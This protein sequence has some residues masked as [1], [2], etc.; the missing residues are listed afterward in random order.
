MINSETKK[1]LYIEDNIADIRLFEEA[2]SH[3]NLAIDLN[4]V[5]D[6]QELIDYFTESKKGHY[7]DLPELIITDLNLP[8][9]SGQKVIEVLKSDP[10][11]KRIPVI[12]FTTSNLPRDIEKCYAFGA[13]AYMH[14][15][16]DIDQVFETI[17]LIDKYWLRTC[18]LLTNPL[19]ESVAEGTHI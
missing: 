3:Q 12:V 17:E 1:V 19:G 7:R 10:V 9:I 14:K 8:K 13:N 16:L 6:G 2:I 4:Y 18:L 5:T 11:Y 15:P